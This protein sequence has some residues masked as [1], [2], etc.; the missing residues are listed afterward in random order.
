MSVQHEIREHHARARVLY[1]KILRNANLLR[2]DLDKL[3]ATTSPKD[4]SNVN[5][6]TAEFMRLVH[7]MTRLEATIEGL[8][9]LE[10]VRDEVAVG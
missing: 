4:V 1:E 6:S 8:E 2:M 10:R 7:D 5:L 3:Y 9:A